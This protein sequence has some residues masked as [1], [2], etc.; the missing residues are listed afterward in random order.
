MIT[1]FQIFKVEN[2]KTDKEPD[3]RLTAKVDDT[4]TEIGAGWIKQ[5]PKGTKY[6]SVKMAGAF[7]DRKGW[8]ITQVGTPI[9]EK[10]VEDELLNIPF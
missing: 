5:S 8:E 6:I 1:N 4:Y 2:K 9:T 10:Q 3:Y 7:K